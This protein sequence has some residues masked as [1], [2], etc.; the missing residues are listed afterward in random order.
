MPAF[1]IIYSPASQYHKYL[2]R[3][4]GWEAV[5]S[6]EVVGVLIQKTYMAKQHQ[7][8]LFS[9]P[10][11]TTSSYVHRCPVLPASLVVIFCQLSAWP[12]KLESFKGHPSTH[13]CQTGP[14]MRPQQKQTVELWHWPYT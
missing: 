10:H 9:A 4:G 13:G 6:H 8:R 2:Y 11:I 14:W 7:F 1:L 5:D 3:G 12:G